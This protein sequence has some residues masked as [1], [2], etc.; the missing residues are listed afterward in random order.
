MKSQ[1]QRKD[2]TTKEELSGAFL[3]LYDED[4]E[5]VESWTLKKTPHIMK[6][7]RVSI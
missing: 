6:N 7:L 2:A 1:S 4:G 5:V 3:V